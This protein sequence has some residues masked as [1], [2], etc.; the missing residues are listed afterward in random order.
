MKTTQGRC[1]KVDATPEDVGTISCEDDR[2]YIF[3]CDDA[4][5]GWRRSTLHKRKHHDL[6]EASCQVRSYEN[7]FDVHNLQCLWY[8]AMCPSFENE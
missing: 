3:E 2:P 6:H 5:L 7:E 8:F 1:Q 4:W